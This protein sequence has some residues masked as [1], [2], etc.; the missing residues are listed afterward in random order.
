MPSR[1]DYRFRAMVN[2]DSQDG[3]LVRYL[4][5]RDSEFSEKD[6]VLWATAAY[7]LPLALREQKNCSTQQLKQSA[8]TSIYKLRQH[9]NYLAQVF[10][11]EGEV[12]EIGA[13]PKVQADSNYSKPVDE[14]VAELTK[15]EAS[16]QPELFVRAAPEI[17]TDSEIPSLLHHQDDETFQT[18]FG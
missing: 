17:S 9:I 14:P 4:R 3:A 18:L 11:L 6:M 5:S 16:N 7:W 1:I 8:R 10:G 15:T 13:L 12:T 2:A